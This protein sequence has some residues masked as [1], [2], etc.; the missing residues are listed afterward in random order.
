MAL[1]SNEF[2]KNVL[3]HTKVHQL[4]LIEVVTPET[5]GVKVLAYL[6]KL[7]YDTDKHNL[8]SSRGG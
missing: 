4:N 3:P 6:P 2:I 5:R 1:D 7:I 8:A